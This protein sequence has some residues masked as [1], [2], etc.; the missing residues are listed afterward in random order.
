MQIGSSVFAIALIAAS[1]SVFAQEGFMLGST[2]EPAGTSTTTTTSNSSNTTTTTTTVT[3]YVNRGGVVA[4]KRTDPNTCRSL[5][6]RIDQLN[7]TARQALPPW[8]HDSI[9][10]QK[11]DL[12]SQIH[13]LKC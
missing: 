5:Y 10:Q 1:M 12:F 2:A 9:N 13:N 7:A 3:T 11:R 8:Q 6:E 4:G